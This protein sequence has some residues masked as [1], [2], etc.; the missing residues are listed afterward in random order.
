GLARDLGVL[1]VELEG[2]EHAR[3]A[4]AAEEA[5]ARVAGERA[6][7]DRPAGGDEAG[8]HLEVEA[9]ERADVDVGQPGGARALAHVGEELVLGGEDAVGVLLELG[10]GVAE[11]FVHAESYTSY[12]QRAH[13]GASG[14]GSQSLFAAGSAFFSGAALGGVGSGFAGVGSLSTGFGGGA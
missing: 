8:Q 11:R 14:L 1:G 4:H 3:R 10:V 7:L 2:V 9:V 5:G 13:S 12:L 6:D